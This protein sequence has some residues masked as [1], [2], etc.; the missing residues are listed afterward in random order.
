MASKEKDKRRPIVSKNDD[1]S[2]L[3]NDAKRVKSD[4]S[5]AG[6]SKVSYFITSAFMK[7]DLS[8]NL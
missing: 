3:K 8:Q 6:K 1:S 7:S 5:T 2:G 4:D